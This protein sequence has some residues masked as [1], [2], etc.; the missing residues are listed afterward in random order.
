[1]VKNIINKLPKSIQKALTNKYIL[2]GLIL[3]SIINIIGYVELKQWNPL[4]L[5]IMTIILMS[6]FTKNMTII[7]LAAMIMGNCL[8]CSNMLNNYT[9]LESFREGNDGGTNARYYKNESTECVEH[10]QPKKEDGGCKGMGCEKNCKVCYNKN[11]C[12][13]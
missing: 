9:G 5:Y 10:T 12:K 7:I 13:G 8:V 4:A 1:M 11:T 3:I 6:Y 2:C